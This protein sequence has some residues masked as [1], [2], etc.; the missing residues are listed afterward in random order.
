[1]HS[2]NVKEGGLLWRH[3]STAPWTGAGKVSL[4][5]G[6]VLSTSLGRGVSLLLRSRFSPHVPHQAASS[7]YCKLCLLHNSG[8]QVPSRVLHS[9]MTLQQE[10]Q[11]KL[12]SSLCFLVQTSWKNMTNP[13]PLQSRCTV[14][15]FW[16]HISGAHSSHNLWRDSQHLVLKLPSDSSGDRGGIHWGSLVEADWPGGQ[17]HVREATVDDVEKTQPRLEWCIRFL[18]LLHQITTN[19]VA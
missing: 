3:P 11:D 6:Q 18:V 5:A 17:P 12:A 10:G 13:A 9:W 8:L 1:M 4:A 14:S 19:L 15:N 2:R 7:A 16:G